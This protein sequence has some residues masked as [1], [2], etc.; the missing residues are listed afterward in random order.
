MKKAVIDLKKGNPIV[1]INV[2]RVESVD[3]LVVITC[4][5]KEQLLVNK[6]EILTIHLKKEEE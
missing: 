6:N 1:M 3:G 5:N 4:T 2:D